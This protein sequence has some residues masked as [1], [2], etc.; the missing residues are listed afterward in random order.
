MLRVFENAE[1]L[2][3]ER[4]APVR[5]SL[6]VRDGRI[7]ERLDADTPLPGDVQRI[8]LEGLS[9]APGFID[10]HFHGELVF[11]RGDRFSELLAHASLARLAEG[12][13]G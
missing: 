11:A 6:V 12:P 13:P 8:D 9:L 1:L 4:E 3:P 2:D 5:A 7:V 10:L